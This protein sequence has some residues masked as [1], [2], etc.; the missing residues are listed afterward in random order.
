[1]AL[2]GWADVVGMRLHALIFGPA[3]AV[4]VLGIS[5]DPKVDA[6]LGRLRARPIGTADSLDPDALEQAIRAALEDEDSQRRDREARAEHL[7]GLA[8]RNV[9]RALVLLE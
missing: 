4:P 5:Y 1:M 2:A 8:A 9:E 7:R 6:L 3:R